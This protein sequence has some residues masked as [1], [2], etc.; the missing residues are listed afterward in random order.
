MNGTTIRL[1][2]ASDGEL[3]LSRGAQRLL[4]PSDLVEI[5]PGVEFG[6][7]GALSSTRSLDV[8][9]VVAEAPTMIFKPS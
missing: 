9:S 4:G 6:R 5:F 2:G 1:G 8:S 3:V 7:L